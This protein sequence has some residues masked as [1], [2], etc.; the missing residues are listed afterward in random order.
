M[1]FTLKV[2]LNWRFS[3]DCQNFLVAAAYLPIVCVD[4]QGRQWWV[5]AMLRF[6]DHPAQDR[7]DPVMQESLGPNASPALNLLCQLLIGD[8]CVVRLRYTYED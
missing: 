8:H 1:V 4:Y 7:T 2:V 6:T 5:A 3:S